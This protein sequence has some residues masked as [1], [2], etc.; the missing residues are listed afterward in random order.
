M[1]L[2]CPSCGVQIHFTSSVSVMATCTHCRATVIRNEES[3][4][5]LGEQ[6]AFMDDLSPFQ[7]MTEGKYE[8][9]RFTLLGRLKIVY[10]GGTWSEWYAWFDDGNHGWL[11]EAQGLYM[12][13]F[14]K[15]WDTHL[16]VKDF[17]PGRTELTLHGK[18]FIV[19]DVKE[20]EY[21]GMEGELPFRFTPGEKATSIDCRGQD[22]EF[23]SISFSA[24]EKKLYFGYYKD[25]DE[26]GF[27]NLRDLSGW[28]R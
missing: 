15:D 12:M 10:D 27:N 14:E 3:L 4:K 19:D 28:K 5:N 20:V 6:S 21:K 2:N 9:R 18:K 13:S 24:T 11:A 26:I 17:T 23:A 22:R 8:N 7:V 1:E 16:N 25:F